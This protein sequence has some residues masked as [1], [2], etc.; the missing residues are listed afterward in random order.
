[1]MH[2]AWYKELH[3]H[4]KKGGGSGLSILTHGEPYR[5]V[6]KSIMQLRM[7]ICTYIYMYAHN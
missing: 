5:A 1:M 2:M 7:C 3:T 6:Q 4:K